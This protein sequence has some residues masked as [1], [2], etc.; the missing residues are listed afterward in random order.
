MTKAQIRKAAKVIFQMRVAKLATG[1]ATR[2]DKAVLRKRLDDLQFKMRL[3][4]LI[5]EPLQKR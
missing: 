3:A 4:H 2:A 5:D 1:S